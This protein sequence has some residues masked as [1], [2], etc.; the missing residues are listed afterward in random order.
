MT[1]ERINKIVHDKLKSHPDRYK[2]VLGVAKMAEK[3][4]EHYH[5]DV[6]TVKIAAIFHDY[7]KYDDLE[8]QKKH[9]SNE[10]IAKYQDSPVI[11]HALAAAKIIETEFNV[12]DESIISAISKHV[13]GSTKMSLIDKIVLISDKIE[14]NRDYPLVYELR[15]TVFI[16]IDQTIHRFLVDSIT[17]NIQ[18][19]NNIHQEQY[20]VIKY[21]EEKLNETD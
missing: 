3:L 18:K 20:E 10:Q 16:N 6:E 9:L 8:V 7:A 4:A 13:W 11:F 5:V 14:E 21:L 15:K 1:Y 19:G 17:H 2:H 12:T